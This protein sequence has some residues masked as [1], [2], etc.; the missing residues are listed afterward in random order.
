MRIT[1]VVVCV[2]IIL[3]VRKAM[4][5]LVLG[6]GVY[7]DNIMIINNPPH[8]H[9]LATCFAT[10]P[11]IRQHEAKPLPIH[12]IME[13]TTNNAKHNESKI[14]KS[15][16]IIFGPLYIYLYFHIFGP[17][18]LGLYDMQSNRAER[19]SEIEH[20]SDETIILS[21]LHLR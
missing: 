18:P 3:Y 17:G 13:C 4:R 7:N 20:A 1:C 15:R 8:F 21:C 6:G 19:M 2:K 14:R 12:S 10:Y 11:H 5:V 16:K 9:Q